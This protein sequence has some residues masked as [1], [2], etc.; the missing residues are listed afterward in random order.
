MSTRWKY[1]QH[2][3][4]KQSRPENYDIPRKQVVPVH[5][6]VFH[7]E[8]LHCNALGSFEFQTE[9]FLWM[10]NW[11]FF[12]RSLTKREKWGSCDCE[13]KKSS[14]LQNIYYCFL[15]LKSTSNVWGFLSPVLWLTSSFLK[16]F[17]KSC[18]RSCS[19]DS[20]DAKG[21]RLPVWV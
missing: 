9:M 7:T 12:L 21:K 3:S 20:F 5:S 2:A 10:R 1:I 4:V 11:F 8:P 19:W 13:Q 6:H 17:W 16:L 14:S 15:S 18:R